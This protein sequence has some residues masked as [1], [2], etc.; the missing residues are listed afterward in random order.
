MARRAARDKRSAS[1]VDNPNPAL[2]PNASSTT[3]TRQRRLERRAVRR[4]LQ[5]QGLLHTS[6]LLLSELGCE[7]MCEVMGDEGPGTEPDDLASDEHA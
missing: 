3:D 4:G 5:Q 1:V 6:L 2:S 7:R